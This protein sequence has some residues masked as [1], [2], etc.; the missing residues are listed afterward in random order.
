MA[1]VTVSESVDIQASV[2]DVFSYR[3]AFATLPAYN[4]NVT[5][6]RRTDGGTDPGVG[7]TYVFDLTL[8]GAEE[9][10]EVPLRVTEVVP[11][12]RIVFDVGPGFMASEV[13]SFEAV[14]G[15]TRVTFEQTITIDGDLG[16]DVMGPLGASAAEQ[17]RLEL[18]LIKKNLET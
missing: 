1:S 16:D 18:D 10:M 8:P 11:N 17:A 14:E 2:Q 7:A 6:I 3:L 13:C 12:E 15:G 4:P 9:P 5:N